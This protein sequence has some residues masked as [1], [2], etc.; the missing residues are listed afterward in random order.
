LPKGSTNKRSNHKDPMNHHRLTA[1]M[2]LVAFAAAVK[3]ANTV[4][5]GA[6]ETWRG[7]TLIAQGQASEQECVDTIVARTDSGATSYTCRH[8]ITAVA[9]QTP[10]VQPV[11][12]YQSNFDLTE[13]PIREGGAWTKA[14]NP[15]K[16]VQTANG[17]AFAS[18]HN[19]GYDDNYARLTGTWGA[20]QTIEATVHIN[21]GAQLG[22]N[23]EVILLVRATD[24]TNNIR[25]MEALFSLAGDAYLVKWNG[26]LGGFSHTSYNCPP[27]TPWSGGSPL[28]TG[29]KLKLTVA[30]SQFT[31][32]VNNVVKWC[33]VD[34]TLQGGSP[35]IA[36]YLQPGT[37]LNYLTLT[38][39]RATSN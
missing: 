27:G 9:A 33:T 21:A 38:D 20:N 36:F 29:D 22:G 31:M 16:Y 32:Y 24:D 28:R 17:T 35:G 8:A 34:T 14:N 3:A 15:W 25:A 4:T 6:W 18:A 10:A 30:G 5:P 13:Y 23:P 37:A 11:A 7:S 12:S 1:L 39:V 19:Q 26:P 2:G